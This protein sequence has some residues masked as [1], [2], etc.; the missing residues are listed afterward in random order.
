[1]P[2]LIVVTL[3][4]AHLQVQPGGKASANIIVKNRSEEVENFTLS[5]EGVPPAWGDI[6][7]E[8]LSAFPF[9]EVR[10]QINVHPPAE[11][12]GALYR[13][14]I[15]AK[16]QDQAGTEG[17]GLLE[18]EV[19]AAPVMEADVTIQAAKIP[20]I[21]PAAGSIPRST[22]VRPQTAV[23]I[24]LRVEPSTENPLPP[25]AMQWKL[26]LKNA[27]NVLDTFGF[28]FNG[29][30]QN[31]PGEEGTSL[32][33]VRPGTDTK[34][35]SYPFTLRAFS[36]VNMNER[37]EVSFKV[38][39]KASLGFQLEVTPH[40]A[41][42]QG[43]REFQV[44]LSS[45]PAA[46]GDMWVDLAAHDQ[47]NA[48]D[49][50]FQPKEIL[51]PA[52]QRVMSTLRIKPRAV[53]GPNERKQYTVK[54]EAVPRQAASPAQSVD[55]RI[56]HAGSLPPSLT[57]QPQVQNAEMESDYVVMVANPS[58]VDVTLYFSADD[59]EAA[60]DYAFLPDR[61]FIS[62][63]GTSSIRLH[64]KAH[65]AYRGEKPKQIAF[66]VKATRGGE[67]VPAASVQGQLNQT[68]GR[69]LTVQLIPPQ[70]SS[71]G[72]AKFSTRVHNP[73]NGT[74]LSWLEA[75]DETDALAFSVT[76]RRLQIAAGA[77]GLFD[78]GVKPKDKLL[79]TDQR[80][81]HKFTVSVYVQ[82]LSTPTNVTGLLAQ[83]KGVNWT[84]PIGKFFSGLLAF[85]IAVFKLLFKIIKW[86]IPII[87]IL[88]VIIFVA[89]LGIATLFYI[90]GHDNQLGPIITG[91][92]PGP[93]I[94]SLHNT[95]LFKGISDSIVSAAAKIMA[96]M[97]TRLNPPPTPTPKP[98][99]GP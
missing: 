86:A 96:V 99:T 32:L 62:A 12:Q 46:N 87:L 14:T 19:P 88:I 98:T 93:M 77:D 50:G 24:E 65:T 34:A 23:Q 72:R 38:D 51:L 40:E 44:Y 31:L 69:P 9:Q 71:T 48:C 42:I 5:L 49:Y 68:P 70:L 63:N 8:Q 17:R 30:A 75:R 58:A 20:A 81:V 78:L 83:V 2:D 13:L 21:Q 7:P 61:R 1:M 57:I 55:L 45:T 67:L 29:V 41:E 56:T 4:P 89:D 10:A 73:Y 37:T 47:D 26:R 94:T 85:I 16:T 27:G 54:V 92:V 95:M 59:P 90:V 33:V 18:V 39:V 60:C 97:Q 76:P 28:S 80:R 6:N 74:I 43:M 11:I 3:D 79:P 84:T 15:C 91:L 66:I 53:L 25:P 64:V 22:P 52:R 36:H 82:G 35:G